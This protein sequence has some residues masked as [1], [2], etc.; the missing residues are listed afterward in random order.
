MITSCIMI[1]ILAV[2]ELQEVFRHTPVEDL[3][4]AP[5]LTPTVFLT[6][7]TCPPAA[8]PVVARDSNYCY[9]T[10]VTTAVLVVS[11]RCCHVP[12][13]RVQFSAGGDH[14]PSGH[15]VPGQVTMVMS[16]SSPGG[17]R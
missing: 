2:T 8:A 15:S 12:V 11:C 3:V 6:R 16:V 13:A 17:D 7:V 14:G 5:A 10:R 9:L 1:I 4:L